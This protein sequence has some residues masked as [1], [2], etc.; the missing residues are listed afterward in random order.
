MFVD[1][2]IFH[3]LREVMDLG[4]TPSVMLSGEAGIINY[5]LWNNL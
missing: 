1:I 5:F 3:L 2:A 4:L